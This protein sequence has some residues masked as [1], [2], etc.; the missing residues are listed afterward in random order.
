MSPRILICNADIITMDDGMG[1][2]KRAELPIEGER[3]AAVG[4]I[5]AVDAEMIDGTGFMVIPG[6]V[7]AHMHTWQTGLRG[8]AANW[9]LLEYFR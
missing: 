6:L 1:D 2:L 4:R 3:I 7:D 8:I 5:G 9:T